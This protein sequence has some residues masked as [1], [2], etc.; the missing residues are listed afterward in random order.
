M[1]R[2]YWN[3]EMFPQFAP[4]HMVA[5]IGAFTIAVGILLMIIGWINSAI[6]GPKVGSN[7]WKSKSLEWTH[8][9]IIAGPGNFPH[10]VTV[11]EDWT[12]YEYSRRDGTPFEADDAGGSAASLLAANTMAKAE[13]TAEAGAESVAKAEADAAAK[14]VP[15]AAKAKTTARSTAPASLVS[16]TRGAKKDDGPEF[17]KKARG[18][19]ADDLKRIKG[20]GPKLEGVLNKLGVFHFDQ[21]AAWKA[22]DV[23]VVDGRLNFKGRIKRDTWVK[24]AKLLAAGKE[25]AFSKRVDKGAVPSSKG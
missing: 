6:R 1:P 11:D 7:P 19:K 25:T 4:W 22:K 10:P 21:I 16:S 13:L 9:E 3:Y 20:V 24:Q 12:P 14:A 17:L 8:T 2:R 15:K 5:T 18:G 23:V